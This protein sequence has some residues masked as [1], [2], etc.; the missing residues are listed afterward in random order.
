MILEVPCYRFQ[1][2]TPLELEFNLLN[3]QRVEQKQKQKQR[4][5]RSERK[6]EGEAVTEAE[7]K[8]SIDKGSCKGKAWERDRKGVGLD[9]GRA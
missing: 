7:A 6:A 4:R 8:Y 5:K 2:A 3:W 1:R 9:I